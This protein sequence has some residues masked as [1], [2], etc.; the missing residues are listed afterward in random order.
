MLIHL[1]RSGGFAGI[2]TDVT[3]DAESLPAED[4]RKIKEMLDSSGF[5]NMPSKFA[6]PKRGADFF[7]YR[8]TVKLEGKEHTVEMSDP[9]VPDGLRALL[10]SVMK[11]AR[12]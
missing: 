3:L 5:F 7:N 1:E 10:Q 9:Q 4:A 12:K 8:I 11:Y 2:K 6:P